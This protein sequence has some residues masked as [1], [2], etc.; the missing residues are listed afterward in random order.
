MPN[1]STSLSTQAD[2]EG[3]ADSI[4]VVD[5]GN[6]RRDEEMRFDVGD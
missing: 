6:E 3:T 2:D 1:G 4:I 5:G